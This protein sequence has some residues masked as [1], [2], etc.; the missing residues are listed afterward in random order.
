MGQQIPAL[1]GEMHM[2]NKWNGRKTTA[3]LLMGAAFMVLMI[4]VFGQLWSEEALVTDF[5]R[6]NMAPC[7]NYLFGTDFMGRNM[8]IRTITGLSMSIR[9]GFLTAAVSAV[10][11]L[12]LALAAAAFGKTADIFI[13]G[14]ID[15]VMG[16]P[17]MLLLILIAFACGKGFWGVVIGISL[18]HWTS[19]ARLI[20]AEIIQ[21][22][23]YPYIK[24]AE[25]LGQGKIK[26]A[27]R[28][29]VPHIMPQFW[30]GLVLLFPHAI[31]HEAGVTFL[32][33]GLP[34]EQP[35]IGI[36]LSESISYLSMGK[37]WLAVFPGILLA[38]TVFLF[39]FIGQSICAL[40]N[41]SS[42]QR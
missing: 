5:S 20:R 23:E 41:P 36:I 38:F 10:I 4:T 17:H 3:L 33:F 14:V 24:I 21:L 26:I 32:G 31:L 1:E 25:R 30:V 40:F 11:A 37:W 2:K 42:T 16:I 13:L 28:H 19:L 27:F 9:I 15:L 6:K 22:K 8:F 39:H 35:A 7:I 18:T 12:I 29:M 34:P